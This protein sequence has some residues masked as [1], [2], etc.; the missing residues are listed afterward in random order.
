MT[1]LITRSPF[2]GLA[3]A[4]LLAAFSFSFAAHAEAELDAAQAK[5]LFNARGCNACHGAEE[6]RIGPSYQ[7][8]AMRYSGEYATDAVGLV[9]K[10]ATKIRYGGTGAWG[11][12]PMIS[13][14][15]ISQ[16]E[17][18]SIS[19]WILSLKPPAPQ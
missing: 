1:T 5:K 16:V 10:L 9:E 15:T 4:T 17:A 13:N 14:P 19:R 3:A 8:I 12:V 7:V 2:H 11:M 6:Q 18:E